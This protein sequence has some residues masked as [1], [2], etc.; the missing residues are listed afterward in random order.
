MPKATTLI[1]SIDNHEDTEQKKFFATIGEEECFLRYRYLADD[2]VD[3]FSTYVPKALGGRGYAAQL[4]EQGLKFCRNY[5]LK[6]VPSCSYVRAYI[7]KHSE[8]QN[9]LA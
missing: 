7:G 3:F 4:V 9:L 2:T 1:I 5:G 8:Y 6:V